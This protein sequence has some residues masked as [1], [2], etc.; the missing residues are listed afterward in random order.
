MK[1]TKHKRWR[2][3]SSDYIQLWKYKL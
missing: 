1:K 2:L 3:S